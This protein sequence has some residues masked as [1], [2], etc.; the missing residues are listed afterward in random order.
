MLDINLIREKADLVRENIFRRKNDE[1]LSM[2]DDLVKK[3]KEYRQLL[4]EVEGLRA[5]RNKLSKE[6]AQ[7]KKEGKNADEILKQVADLP[8][9]IKEKEEKFTAL[10]ET[11]DNYLMQLPNL[12]HDSVPYGKDDS[13]NVEIR[14]WGTPRKFD[15]EVKNHVELLEGLG[16]AD[17]DQSSTVSGHGFYYLKG[18]FALLN[19][20]LIRF[21]IDFMA[22]KN[23]IYVEPPLMLHRKPYEGATDVAAFENVM[24]KIEG[25]DLYLIATAE[26]PLAALYMD[27]TIDE[28]QSPIRLF[29]YSMCFRKEVGSR[30]IDTKGLFRTHQFNKVEQF[31]FCKPE[32]SLQLHEEITKNSEEML[33]ALNLPYRV[34]NV[35][36][37]D[38]GPIAAKKYDIET[39]FPRQ[40]GYKET[41]SSSNC[42]DYQAR[43]LN[44]K[45]GKEGGNKFFAHTLNN[46]AIATSRIMVAICENY[47]QKDG[48]IKVPDVL[49]SFMNG[50]KV[51]G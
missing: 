23:Y 47:Q 37:G 24:Y 16:V 8:V 22:K 28:G 17:F 35:C 3:D 14:K 6:V 33:Q 1:Y 10:K 49:V 46:T 4:Q 31:I 50:K 38:L 45:I 29:G 30:G 39:Y 11:V 18:D 32:E 40:N 19:N 12:L 34:V 41:M 13:E 27:K 44:V 48:K 9:Q 42:T 15:F 7:L 25:D 43:R 26:H 51:I 20:A 21:A 36:T 2:F 5:L